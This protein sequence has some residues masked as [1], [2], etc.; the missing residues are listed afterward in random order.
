[1]YRISAEFA[2]CVFLRAYPFRK[3]AAC[4]KEKIHCR[5]CDYALLFDD[6]LRTPCLFD[7]TLPFDMLYNYSCA[8][9]VGRRAV[10][11]CGSLDEGMLL[12]TE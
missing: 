10:L 2:T 3:A 12:K 9:M 7:L 5:S 6:F 8:D 4:I 11:C 1:L